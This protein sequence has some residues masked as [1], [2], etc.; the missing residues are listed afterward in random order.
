MSDN[1]VRL[2]IMSTVQ[3]KSDMAADF[4]FMARGVDQAA[5]G[6]TARL[7]AASRHVD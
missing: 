6:V 2:E 5:R 7:R 1:A 4:A 3:H